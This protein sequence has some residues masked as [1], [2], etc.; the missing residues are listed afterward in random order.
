MKAYLISDNIDSFV[1]L[2]IAG[3][4]GS[5]VHTQEEALAEISRAK[6]DRDIGILILT[7]KIEELIPE[8]VKELKLSKKLP[9][10]V[11]IP[12]RHGSSKGENSITKYVKESIGLK[13]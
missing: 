7:E 13:I 5:V 12:D 11:Q 2:K 9:L 3:I 6:E 1:G 10:V 4:K 8:K